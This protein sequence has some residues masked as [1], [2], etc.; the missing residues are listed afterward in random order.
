MDIP[1]PRRN[2]TWRDSIFWRA[3]WQSLLS[4]AAMMA[5]A[6]PLT[7]VLAAQTLRL[8]HLP[9]HGLE[10]ARELAWGWLLMMPYLWFYF[11][12][13]ERLNRQKPGGFALQNSSTGNSLDGLEN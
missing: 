5:L 8:A 3:T 6:L 12:A 9:F 10:L 13:L 1:L 2:P 7:V 4:G 11:F